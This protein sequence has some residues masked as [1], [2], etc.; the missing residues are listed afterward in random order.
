MKPAEAAAESIAALETFYDKEALAK[1]L[2]ADLMHWCDANGQ[3]FH[4]ALGEARYNYE[5]EKAEG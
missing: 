3:D 1:D 5:A 2:M 4:V